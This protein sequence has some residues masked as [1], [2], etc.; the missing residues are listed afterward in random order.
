MTGN[1]ARRGAGLDPQV[2]APPFGHHL[3]Q[4]SR[5]Q[6]FGLLEAVPGAEYDAQAKDT[7]VTCHKE[8]KSVLCGSGGVLVTPGAHYA[9]AGH[10]GGTE[11]GL[12]HASALLSSCT[13]SWGPAP[14]QTLPWR[15][16]EDVLGLAECPRATCPG[17]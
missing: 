17:R 12:S 13:P 8:C 14:S 16:T 9:E 1:F 3:D 7:E 15:V 4:G 11:A 10:V 6:L 5:A 2:D